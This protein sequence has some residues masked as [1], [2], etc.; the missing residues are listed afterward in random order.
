MQVSPMEFPPGVV[1]HNL[2]DFTEYELVSS[3][4]VMCE[5]HTTEDDTCLAW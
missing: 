5:V 4:R 3:G 2:I 1:V